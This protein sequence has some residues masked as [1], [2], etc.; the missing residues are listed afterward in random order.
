MSLNAG[1]VGP[2]RARIHDGR[3]HHEQTRE[4]P[5]QQFGGE[6]QIGGAGAVSDA[7]DVGEV[8]RLDHGADIGCEIQEV[9]VL[10]RRL[11]AGAMAAAVDAVDGV[12]RRQLAR[13]LVPDLGDEA[14][15][16]H[17]QG[18]RLVGAGLAPSRQ[19]NAPAGM[20]DPKAMPVRHGAAARESSR[21]IAAPFSAI[22]AVGVLVL[23]D[24]MVGITEAST[25]RSPAR[26]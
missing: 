1:S 16:V 10:R 21:I 22:I 23:P 9:I 15:A 2:D 19:R 5:G 18:R 8:E 11:V 20:F 7:E 26:P 4:A 25:T 12:S 3:L 14:G 13:D 6:Q 17:Q 24:V